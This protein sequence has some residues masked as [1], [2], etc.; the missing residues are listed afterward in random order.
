VDVR[1]H[2]RPV[3]SPPFPPARGNE[4]DVA[5]MTRCPALEEVTAD[6]RRARARS[7]QHK[8]APEQPHRWLYPH[9]HLVEVDEDD[10]QSDG[11]RRKVLQLEPVVLQQR[12]EGGQWPLFL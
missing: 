10:H 5:G 12:E 6:E 7:L 11:V 8:E 2:Q 3:F 4:R 1:L 9:V